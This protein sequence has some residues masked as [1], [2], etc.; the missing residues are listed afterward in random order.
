MLLLRPTFDRHAD[1]AAQNSGRIDGSVVLS[2][3]LAAKRIR[4]RVYAEPGQGA[5]PPPQPAAE[6]RD[7]YANVVVYLEL[8]G[9]KALA[10]APSHH[11]LRP[12]MVQ[13]GEVFRPHVLAVLVGA[14]VE[15]PNEDEVFHNVFSLS[16]TR[17]F[18]LPK[19]PAGASRSV[20]FPRVGIVNLF[21]H[22][23]ADMSAVILVRDNPYF[24]SPDTAGRF[25]LADI[26]PG[27]YVLVAWH[28]RIKPVTQRVKIVAGQATPVRFDIPLPQ[29]PDRP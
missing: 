26:P 22:I 4:F 15:F 24:V 23:H 7:E 10:N 25:S 1:L 16:G 5:T 8:D 13:R 12:A 14:T 3:A 21:C 27:D 11:P 19:Y 17:Q 9:A 29:P 2:R 6:L 28:E 20:A 18:D